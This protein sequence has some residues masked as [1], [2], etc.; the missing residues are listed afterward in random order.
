MG[1]KGCSGGECMK[2]RLSVGVALGGAEAKPNVGDGRWVH[3]DC[4]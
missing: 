4:C 2:M 1:V 3:G